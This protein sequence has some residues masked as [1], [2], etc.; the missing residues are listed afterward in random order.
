MALCTVSKVI[1]VNPSYKCVANKWEMCNNCIDIVW[2]HHAEA[3]KNMMNN[4]FYLK[5]ESFSSP[6]LT[7][8]I[9]RHHCL[10]I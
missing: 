3:P 10:V 2:N 5:A 9:E 7:A 1:M 6:L 8:L 4:I